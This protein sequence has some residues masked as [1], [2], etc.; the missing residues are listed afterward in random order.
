MQRRNFL[1]TAGL[2]GLALGLTPMRALAAVEDPPLPFAPSPANGWRVFEVTTR[3]ELLKPEGA[4]QVWLPLPAVEQA[5]W[6]RPLGDRWTSN[7]LQVERLEDPVYGAA[8]LH[9][10][11]AADV[12]PELQV[13]SRFT[14]RDRAVDFSRPG[15][16][17]PLSRAEQQLWTRPTALLPIDGIVRETALAATQG[18]RTDLE[19]ARALYAWVVDNTFREPKTR[20]CGLGDIRAMLETGNLSGKCADLNALYVGLAR[21]VGLPAR[22]VY[23][24][25][26]A[27]SR[28][29]YKSLGKSGTISKA[30]HCRAEVWLADFGWV[31][32][33]PADVR[34]VILEEP[35]G[36]LA[37]DDYRVRMVE[38]RLFGSWETNWLAYNFAHDVVLPGSAGGALPFF[39]YPQAETSSGRQDSLDPDSFKYSITS[40]EVATWAE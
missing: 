5:A 13:V 36:K 32:V 18:A 34:K 11:W 3:V 10:R 7:A 25:R 21:A 37:R 9:A 20:G 30:Q 31:P 4:A 39:M 16:V 1:K 19:K 27:D 29:G 26:V 6:I 2:T 23:G 38:H 12:A 33:D 15:K 17:A 40:R 8:F 24:I 14:A 22:D 35:P 28:Y